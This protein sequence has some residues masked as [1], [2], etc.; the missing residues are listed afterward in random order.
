MV[1]FTPIWLQSERTWL[2]VLLE[3]VYR[4]IREIILYENVDKI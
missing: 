3:G 1:P 2:R 4:L